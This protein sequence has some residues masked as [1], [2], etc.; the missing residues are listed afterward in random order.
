MTEEEVQTLV[1]ALSKR[2]PD[3]EFRA[4]PF[5]CRTRLGVAVSTPDGQRFAMA[6]P[7]EMDWRALSMPEWLHRFSEALA[8]R[9]K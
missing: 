3:V 2:W 1:A 7:V 5:D 4:E 8:P 9:L 6:T